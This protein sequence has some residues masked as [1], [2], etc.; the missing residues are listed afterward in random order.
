MTQKLGMMGLVISKVALLE[1]K[2]QAEALDALKN[3]EPGLIIALSGD[4]LFDDPERKGD[5][6]H[7]RRASP[8]QAL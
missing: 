5:M 1:I 2:N 7:I 8:R 3:M 6:Y 4:V